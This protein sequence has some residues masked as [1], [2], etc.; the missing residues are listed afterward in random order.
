[1]AEYGHIY[2]WPTEKGKK[3]DRIPW[4]NCSW[5][6]FKLKYILKSPPS[7]RALRS[8]CKWTIGIFTVLKNML[9]TMCFFPPA[10]YLGQTIICSSS[11]V[12]RGGEGLI[13][14]PPP[15]VDPSLKKPPR[16]GFEAKFLSSAN[17][18]GI[19]DEKNGGEREGGWRRARHI[20]LNLL[21]LIWSPVK[22]RKKERKK[23]ANQGF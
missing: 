10:R 4:I 9:T 19:T 15:F 23:K 22:P 17:I 11:K 8:P 20:T 21:M 14:G 6:K 2:V 7:P 13:V 3:K 5:I 1:M 16:E 12:P 18:P